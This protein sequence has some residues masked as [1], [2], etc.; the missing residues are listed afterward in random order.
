M[1]QYFN[2]PPK[3]NQRCCYW[4]KLI[5]SISSNIIESSNKWIVVNP[6]WF[7]YTQILPK[8]VKWTNFCW[9]LLVSFSFHI[10]M[11]KCLL[12]FTKFAVGNK[13]T[14]TTILYRYMCIC[15][16]LSTHTHTSTPTNISSHIHTFPTLINITQA[17]GK[18][19]IHGFSYSFIKKISQPN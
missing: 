1:C 16:N 7:N 9:V 19:D 5:A 15:I 10:Q 14:T 18:R 12:K 2:L 8:W 3:H 13:Y 11:R 4:L 6:K 17:S